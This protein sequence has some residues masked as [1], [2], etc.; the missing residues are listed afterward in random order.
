[1]SRGMRSPLLTSIRTSRSNC[2]R[3]TV[4][5]WTRTRREAR[6]SQRLS[7]HPLPP[8]RPPYV[9]GVLGGLSA[10]SAT[11]DSPV[12]ITWGR[13]WGSTAW[14][15]FDPLAE[16]F[17]S[18]RQTVQ[19]QRRIPNPTLPYVKT[20]RSYNGKCLILTYASCD[21]RADLWVK[22]STRTHVGNVW[23]Q[24]LMVN[25]ALCRGWWWC[26]PEAG[27]LMV[28][29]SVDGCILCILLCHHAT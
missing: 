21:G 23:C 9:P 20:I 17:L 25:V 10:T 7:L 6:V 19:M 16:T 5:Q 28:F 13:T 14:C 24:R 8:H 26:R 27:Q 18:I 3:W 2:V 29:I 4:R 22:G 11:N 15:W 1:M 12:T